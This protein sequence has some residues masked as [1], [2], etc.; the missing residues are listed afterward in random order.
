[1]NKGVDGNKLRTTVKKEKVPE[2]S[3][4]KWVT[5]KDPGGLPVEVPSVMEEAKEYVH[6]CEEPCMWMILLL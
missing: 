1:M 6:C 3:S 4:K 5:G 2:E